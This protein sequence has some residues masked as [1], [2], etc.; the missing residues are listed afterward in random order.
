ML[1]SD[2]T[3]SNNEYDPKERQARDALFFTGNGYFG[4]RG[5]FEEDNETIGAN[6]G[7][8]MTGVFGMGS[9]DAWEGKSSELC[10]LPNVLRV[11]ISCNDEDIDGFSS[12]SDFSQ[13]LDMKKGVYARRYLWKTSDGRRLELCFERFASM[14]DIHRIGQRI[15]IKALDKIDNLSVAALLDSDVTNLN[16]S[17]GEPFPIQPG[18]NHFISRNV[19]TNALSVTLD[20]PDSTVLNFAQ[21]TFA[22]L[23]G[24]A[25]T[26]RIT[27]NSKACGTAYT[28]SLNKNE[29]FTLEKIIFA[30]TS[31]DESLNPEQEIE[32]FLS[33]PASYEQELARHCSALSDKWRVA[34]IEIDTNTTDLTIVR[35]NIYQLLCVCPEHTDRFGIGARGLTG[36]MYEGCVFWDNEIFVL[37]FFLYTNPSAARKQLMFRYHTLDAARRHAKNNW[38]EG[39]MYP[40]QVDRKGVEQTPVNCGAFY[41]IHITGD[42]AFTICRYWELTQDDEFMLSYGAEILYETA[43]FWVSRCDYNSFDGKYHILSVRGPNEYD[44]YVNDNAF[45]NMMAVYNLKS[46]NSVFKK[47]KE[48]HP[49]EF[50]KLFKRLGA[51]HEEISKFCE[52]ADKLN[53]PYNAQMDLYLEDDTYLIRRKLDLKRAKP[54]KKRII[55]STLPYEALPLYQVTKQADTVLLCCL[56][57]H[58]FTKRQ[59]ENVYKFY[60]PRTAHDSSLSYSPHGILAADIGLH[61]EA[62]RYFKESAY[63]DVNDLQLNT[64][65]GLHFANF[66]GT[67]QIVFHGFAGISASNGKLYIKPALPAQW[68][69]ISLH[70]RFLGQTVK[71]AIDK[72]SIAVKRLDGDTPLTVRV[73]NQDYLIDDK[74]LTIDY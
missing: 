51:S 27:T 38:F 28:C 36:E 42:I 35:Y 31:L 32:D 74:P 45:T 53:I 68:S 13:S 43:R 52:V 8:Y 60:E 25:V 71:I 55:D 3:L 10:N 20:D 18:R 4:I 70:C 5:F 72:S 46:V 15:T 67:W 1:Y 64:I 30:V 39:A 66:G 24:K 40:W 59:K 33:K 29:V 2:W 41:A 26:G 16:L 54:T 6:G 58:L 17:S 47:L 14:H 56:F 57:P 62:Y 23:N 69:R 44:V 19:R 50:D 61:E 22:Y 34:D 7:I 12:I 65:N 48:R 37:P 9:Y 21:Q 49:D 73:N 63:L 11:C